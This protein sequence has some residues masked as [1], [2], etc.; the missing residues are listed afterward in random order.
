MNI[1]KVIE[2]LEDTY[3]FEIT[4]DKQI[5]NYYKFKFNYID[6][7]IFEISFRYDPNINEIQNLY[8]LSKEIETEILKF[9]YKE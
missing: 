7:I 9:F 2:K 1:K 3:K 4:C 6:L 8:M 5:G